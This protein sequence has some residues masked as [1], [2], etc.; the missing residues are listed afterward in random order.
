MGSNASRETWNAP[1]YL[2][3]ETNLLLIVLQK[4]IGKVKLQF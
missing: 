4:A 2:A 1:H 3:T